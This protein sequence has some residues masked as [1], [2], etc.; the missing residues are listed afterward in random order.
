MYLTSIFESAEIECN[1]WRDWSLVR[2]HNINAWFFL[3]TG[4]VSSKY[5]RS[6][7]ESI[8]A[9]SKIHPQDSRP[10]AYY[11]SILHDGHVGLVLGRLVTDHSGQ[12][13]LVKQC[14][15][16]K[17]VPPHCATWHWFN[18]LGSHRG[19]DDLWLMLRLPLCRHSWVMY[20]SSSVIL[21]FVAMD[22]LLQL[23][24]MQIEFVN[25]CKML[26]NNEKHVFNWIM[27]SFHLW[28][29]LCLHTGPFL[30]ISCVEL[31]S[32]ACSLVALI[33]QFNWASFQNQTA[34]QFGWKR[35][36]W[37]S[38]A[39][40][41]KPGRPFLTCAIDS[42]SP[43]TT[44]AIPLWIIYAVVQGTLATGPWVIGHWDCRTVEVFVKWH[45][46][47]VYM[48]D[49]QRPLCQPFFSMT[50]IKGSLV[51]KLPS[52]GDLKMQ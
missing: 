23:W 19:Q 24:D 44:A 43:R 52:Y 25:L 16:S 10:D 39:Y 20:Q 8:T 11:M 2:L 12:D 9:L 13:C 28:I 36:S 40:P 49:G 41:W 1:R 45:V 32:H 48:L 7:I 35:S 51:E 38:T 30:W 14:G 31:H 42:P 37:S 21:V 50:L 4:L 15:S 18:K 33:Q 26:K 5:H 3:L 17:L 27:D 6:M 29:C 34:L 47:S 22:W 46:S